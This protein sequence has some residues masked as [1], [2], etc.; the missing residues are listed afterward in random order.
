[1]QEGWGLVAKAG[2]ILKNWGIRQAPNSGKLV[3]PKIKPR[4]KLKTPKTPTDIQI[5]KPPAKDLDLGNMGV[6]PAIN[7]VGDVL[8]RI[9]A[10]GTALI[11]AA[12]YFDDKENNDE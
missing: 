2:T 12:H 1:M 10:G 4:F 8:I 3:P 11:G 5:P 9:G 6:P 7:K